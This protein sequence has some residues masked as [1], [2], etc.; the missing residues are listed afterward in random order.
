VE[1]AG[2]RL[3]CQKPPWGRLT[4]ID[5]AT[6]DIAWQRPLGITQQLPPGKQ[7]TGRPGRAAAIVT[8]GGVVF[9]AATDDNRFRALDAAT[10]GEL[11]VTDLGRHGNANP[12]TYLGRDGKQ[13]V[14]VAATDT[15]M[16]YALP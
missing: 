6:G 13:Y 14:V 10:G 9:I 7:Q 11:W 2:A 4:A 3:P 12:I 5:A 1:I 8:A 15:L 16:A